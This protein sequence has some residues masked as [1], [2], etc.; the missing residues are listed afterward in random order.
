MHSSRVIQILSYYATFIMNYS[1]N[2]IV[3]MHR[4]NIYTCFEGVFKVIHRNSKA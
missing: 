3:L 2:Y 1:Y 4:I